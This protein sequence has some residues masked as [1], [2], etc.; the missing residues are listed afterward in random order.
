MSINGIGSRPTFLG[1]QILDLQNQFTDLQRQLTT[2]KKS[3]TYAGV[4][5][6]RGI[7]IGLRAQI[8]NIN[9]FADTAVN[10]NTRISVANTALTRIAQIA[11][12]TK[13]AAVTSST[14]VTSTGQ[15]QAQS[16][17]RNSLDELLQLL[18]SQA[19]DR[20]LFSGSSTDTPPTASTDEILNGKGLQAGLKQ[21]IT[22]RRA[23][24]RGTI[25]TVAPVTAGR[26]NLT[27]PGTTAP[28]TPTSISITEDSPATPR[29]PFGLK[30][31]SV[32]SSST[33]ITV[34]SPAG[35]P[36]SEKIDL[37]TTNPQPGDTLTF[38]FNLPDGTSENIQLTATDKQPVQPGQYLIDPAGTAGTA[39]NLNGAVSTALG[40]LAN[41][42]L[43]AASA[44][45]AGREFFAGT[46]QR[47][48]L[49][50]P[51]TA[52]TAT[53][54]VAGT[55]A[56][57]LSWYTGENGSGSA[58][59]TATARIDDGVVVQY[60]GRANEPA[61]VAELQALATFAAVTTSTT[62]PNAGAQIT[63]L[64]QRTASNL[65]PQAGQ[66]T[67]Q[68][69]QSDLAGTSVEIK[70][71]GTRQTQAKNTAA[72]LIDSIEGVTNEQISEQILAV[73]NALNASFQTT[74]LLS[75]TSLLKFL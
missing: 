45:Q 47:V 62:D 36:V 56:N 18:N 41:G 30:L 22:E 2:G 32:S 21:L 5:I 7:S 68:D 67:V 49:T 60:G 73:Q 74:A 19:G 48:D 16:T 17:A 69:I 1:S 51:A 29:S 64:Y 33:S 63:A 23:A 43:V 54:L 10:V 59:G 52:A 42:P 40:N 75:Q 50:A 37:G 15:T 66:Q 53:A 57:T 25:S 58:R 38:T 26:L 13:S 4:G 6:N 71:A 72:D 55:P 44:T 11:S 65:Q 27:G 35:D 70:N 20:Y 61:F 9:A 12:D 28:A 8:S 34:T 24:D 46:P 3:N 39:A 14:V 31:A